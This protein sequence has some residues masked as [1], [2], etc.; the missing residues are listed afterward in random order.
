MGY[1]SSGFGIVHTFLLIF[2]VSKAS[3]DIA[4]PPKFFNVMKLWCSKAFLKACEY[5]GR[6]RVLIP[7]GTFMLRSVTF[8]RRVK[9]FHGLFPIDSSKLLTLGLVFVTGD[10]CIAMIAGSQNMDVSNVF[11]GPEHGISIGSLGK[12]HQNDYVQGISI[13]NCT[14]AG[15]ENGVRIKTW[16]PSLNNVM[17]FED[18]VMQNSSNPIVID[19]QYCPRPFCAPEAR[20]NSIF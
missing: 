2:R 11:W 4:L 6:S 15:T 3:E 19:Q 16:S 9:G 17:R 14:I 10:D 1:L 8:Q 20:T 18:I 7:Q 5:G 13:R 12:D